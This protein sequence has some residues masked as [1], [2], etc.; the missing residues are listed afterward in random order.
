LTDQAPEPEILE[1]ETQGKALTPKQR[2][3]IKEYLV[4]FNAT[5]AAIRA[6]YSKESAGSIGSALLKKGAILEQIDQ[7]LAK[8]GG[9][10]RTRIMAELAAIG[11]AN[12]LDYLAA[13]ADISALTPEQAAAI[14]EFTVITDKEGGQHGIKLKMHNKLEA[15]NSMAKAT[16]MHVERVEHSGPGGEPLDG[17]TNRSLARAVLAILSQ[18]NVEDGHDGDTDADADTVKALIEQKE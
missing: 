3:F 10:T 2:L 8:H 1:P 18:A 17:T 15:L 5:Q 9:I 16:R 11:F 13:G 4:D 12:P 14:S 6:K 7:H